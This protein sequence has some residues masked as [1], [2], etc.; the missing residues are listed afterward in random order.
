MTRNIAI[1]KATGGYVIQDTGT[2]ITTVKISFAELVS[3]LSDMFDEGFI[4]EVQRNDKR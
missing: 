2:G 4:V 1:L 3:F